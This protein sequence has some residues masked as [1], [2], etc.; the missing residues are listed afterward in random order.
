MEIIDNDKRKK[1]VPSI[2][3]SFTKD[4]DH[5]VY[6][7]GQK[8]NYKF[9]ATMEYSEHFKADKTTLIE[10]TCLEDNKKYYSGIGLL[11]NICLG[12]CG[13]IQESKRL[14]VKGKYTFVK[15][16]QAVLLTIS[17]N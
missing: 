1:G 11:N 16:G 15:V 4:G 9:L 3:V 13:E 5:Y 2:K 10:W 12:N 14:Q 17:K 8:N 6:G 7:S